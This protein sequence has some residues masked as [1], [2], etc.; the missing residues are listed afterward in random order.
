[1]FRGV[2]GCNDIDCTPSLM[3]LITSGF[4]FNQAFSGRRGRAFPQLTFYAVSM[5]RQLLRAGGGGARLGVAVQAGGAEPA[6]RE[7]SPTPTAFTCVFTAASL[8]FHSLY[9]TCAF[10]AASRCLTVKVGL[11]RSAVL[12]TGGGGGGGCDGGGW[13][14]R[15]AGGDAEGRCAV[16]GRDWR[17][18]VAGAPVLTAAAAAAAAAA[19]TTA[20]PASCHLHSRCR[21]RCRRLE[22]GI[23]EMH[24]A[25]L[26][27][28]MF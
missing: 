4:V 14:D 25:W 27:L 22:D 7:R 28:R 17:G 11:T 24:T 12:D 3:A 15:D 9:F 16:R 26:A 1:M 13:R 2:I 23:H 19:S 5:V 6:V 20:H 18:G 8:D 10:I 21:R